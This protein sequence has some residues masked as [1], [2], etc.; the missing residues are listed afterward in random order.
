MKE[1]NVD[2]KERKGDKILNTTW[3]EIALNLADV[4]R[5]RE[6][7]GEARALYVKCLEKLESIYGENHPQA[8][9]LK[10]LLTSRLRRFPIHLE[11]WRRR[12]ENIPKH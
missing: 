5:K 9:S 11:C 10:I 2:A 1:I 7:F 4:H 8:F 3:A 6:K 12:K